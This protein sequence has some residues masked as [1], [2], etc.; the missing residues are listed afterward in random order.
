[1]GKLIILSGSSGSGKTTICRK[2]LDLYPDYT[3]S[4][5]ATTRAPREN[6][7]AG[8]DYHFYSRREF[9]DLIREDRLAEWEEVHGNLYGTLKETINDALAGQGGLLM[10]VDPKGALHLK[11]IYPDAT[12]IFIKVDGVETLISR[13]NERRTE[14]SEQIAKRMERFREELPLADNFDF[15]IANENLEQTVREIAAIIEGAEGRN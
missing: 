7:R 2:L 3:F 12:T 8:I 6:E 15:V 9:E 5:S 1:M 13:L 4:V 14:S 11:E 10:D